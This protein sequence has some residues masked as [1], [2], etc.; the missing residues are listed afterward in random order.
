MQTLDILQTDTV[1]NLL[2]RLFRLGSGLTDF[3]DRT[4]YVA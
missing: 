4:Q 3:S 1:L 2:Y